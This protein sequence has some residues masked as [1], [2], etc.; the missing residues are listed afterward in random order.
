MDNRKDIRWKQRFA[1]FKKAFAQ[2]TEAV[3]R[4]DVLSQL[5]K[6]GLVQRFEYTFELGWKTLKDYLESKGIDAKYPRDVIKESFRNE[7]IDD[8]EEWLEMLD[9]RNAMAHAYDEE[10][11]NEA[12]REI[13]AK[14]YAKLKHVYEFL[15]NAM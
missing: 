6:E 15:E 13:D 10:V 4:I 9:K 12:V 14:Y 8:G 3:E 2:L 11:F 7:L 5:E 1:N